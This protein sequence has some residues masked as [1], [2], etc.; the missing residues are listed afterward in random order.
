M[1]RLGNEINFS[2]YDFQRRRG[3]SK[4]NFNVP[5]HYLRRLVYLELVNF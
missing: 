1:L 3:I 2:R 4:W 5:E